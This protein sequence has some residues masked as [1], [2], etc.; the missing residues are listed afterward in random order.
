MTENILYLG[1]A[2]LGGGLA[3]LG[4]LFL[5]REVFGEGEL[6]RSPKWSPD[7]QRIVFSRYAGDYRC[8]DT[9]FF[10]CITIKQLQAQFPQITPMFIHKLLNGAERVAKPNFGIARVFLDG[11]E[12]RDINALD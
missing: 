10:G 12:F 8:F 9:E 2:Y 7:G 5:A 4:Q 11:S 3:G 6:L 1:Q